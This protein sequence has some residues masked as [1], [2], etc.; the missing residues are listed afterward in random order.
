MLA[1][2]TSGR[3]LRQSPETRTEQP[4]GEGGVSREAP[5]LSNSYLRG[6]GRISRSVK[7]CS[8]RGVLAAHGLVD[9]QGNGSILR[10]VID[11]PGEV[12]WGLGQ[13]AVRRDDRVTGLQP[14]RSAGEP[15]CTRAT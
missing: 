3:K 8:H 9:F 6:P 14:P 11:D 2:A 13:V 1:R 5:L 10:V 7:R 15:G 12:S 4:K